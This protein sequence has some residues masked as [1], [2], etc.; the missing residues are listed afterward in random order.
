MR[1]RRRA[2]GSF[3]PTGDGVGL[4]DACPRRTL[5]APS[6][7]RAL[8][9]FPRTEIFGGRSSKSCA[10]YRLQK[11]LRWNATRR[12]A[13][14]F[15]SPR[16]IRSQR[17]SAMDRRTTGS[18]PSPVGPKDPP[19]RLRR[20]DPQLR[21]PVPSHRAMSPRVEKIARL[22]VLAEA[23][24]RALFSQQPANGDVLRLLARGDR[25]VSVGATSEG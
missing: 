8:R 15:S 5:F 2:E 9:K 14:D 1:W 22:L 16:S 12:R 24:S 19:A 13:V 20:H 25:A 17:E 11:W 21:S 18:G 23:W 7:S 4:R 10:P 6:R 3:G